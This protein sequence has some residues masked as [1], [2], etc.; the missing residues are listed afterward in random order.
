MIV[1]NEAAVIRRCLESVK[2]HIGYW[3]ISDT[4]SID[5][6]KDIIRETLHSVP[7]ELHDDLWLNFSHNRT[8]NIKRARGKADYLLLMN[9]D[10]VLN[11]NGSIPELNG[12]GYLLRYEGDLDYYALLLVPGDRDWF[13]VGATHEYIDTETSY[14]REKL[15]ALSISHFADGGMR[16]DKYQRDIDLLE[17]EVAAKPDNARA[18][19][20]LAQSYRDIGSLARAMELYERRATMEGWEEETWYAAYQVARMRHLLGIAWPLVLDAYLRAY[21]FRPTRLEPLYHVAR[22]HR[23]NNE[24][25]LAYLYARAVI[26]TPYPDDLLFIERNIYEYLLP[27][28]YAQCCAALGKRDQ[29]ARTVSQLLARADLPKDVRESLGHLKLIGS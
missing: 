16:K 4:G 20:Y 7:G 9:A 23:L 2:P 22:Y 5:A 6:T 26:D 18:V 14:I 19:F 3:V 28:E 13:Y 10:E 17:K 12:E 11:V 15:P 24:P 29:A 27:F 8:V 1:R 25:D 21:S